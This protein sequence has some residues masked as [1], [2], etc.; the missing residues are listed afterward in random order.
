[1]CNCDVSLS[2]SRGSGTAIGSGMENFRT[3]IGDG[4]D[5][6]AGDEGV[7]GSGRC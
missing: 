6:E 7:G 3:T 5:S 1:M 4:V 2:C